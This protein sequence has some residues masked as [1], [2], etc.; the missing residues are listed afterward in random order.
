MPKAGEKVDEQGAIIEQ[1][2]DVLESG[3]TEERVIELIDERMKMQEN[4]AVAEWFLP[5]IHFATDSY[6]IKFS[7]YGNLSGIGKMLKANPTLK[8]VVTGY[9]DQTAS[10]QHNIV[11]SYNRAKA[12]VDHLVNNQGIPRERL[13][14]Q[15]QGMKDALVPSNAN[16]MNRRVEFRSA[17]A[18]D[19]E[20][21][22][23]SGVKELKQGY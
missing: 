19:K 7:D 4:T 2:P 11:L 17:S 12:V 18:K 5:M 6:A 21:I 9:T 8:L 1:D 10:E 20:M 14:I 22:P 13:L 23:P 16:V 15:Y 3:L